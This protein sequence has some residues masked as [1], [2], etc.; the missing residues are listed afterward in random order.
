[1]K[2]IL[3]TWAA[4]LCCS[5]TMTVFTACT[6]DNVDNPVNPTVD[7]EEK[8]ADATILWYGCGGGNVDA[9]IL[10]DFRKFYKAK[11]ESFDRVNV[12][13][14][15]KTSLTPTDYS[16]VDYETVKQWAE[17]TSKLMSEEEMENM[18]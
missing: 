4:V 7:P 5:M 2:K 12:V 15:Y 10:D 8:L 1:M 16:Q 13:A 11:P 18:D 6:I 14:Q 9:A 17:E 3:M